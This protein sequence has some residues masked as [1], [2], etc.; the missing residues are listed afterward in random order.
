[1]T[2]NAA[3]SAKDDPRTLRTVVA[4]SAAG[5]AF[6]WYDFFIFGSLTAV[7]ARHFYADVSEATGY[8]L[9]L[10]TFG[11]G[12]VVRP[13]GA[14]VFGWFGDRTGRKKTFL[15]TITLMGVATVAIGLL[16]DY[17]Q[18]GLAAP[19]LLI[20]MRILQGFALGGEYGGA[21]IYVAEHA[22]ARKRG[23]LT[24]WIQTTAAL[25][26]IGALSVILITRAIVG[27]EAFDEWGWRIPFL[28]SALLL[29]VSLW[30][31]MKLD[32]SPAYERMK[33]EAGEK[34][35]PYV[36]S[37]LRWKNGRFVLIALFGIMI[38]Q[39]AVWYCGYFYAR[40]FM[41]RVLKVEVNTVDQLML[42][43]TALSAFLYVFFAWLSD[44]VGRKPVML[45]G[46]ILA[47]VAYFPGFQALT[48]AANPAL[49]E[50]QATAPVTVV[51]DPA[52]CAVQFD[53][54]GKTAFAS[55]C[56]IAKNVLSNAGISYANEAAAPGT[57]AVVRVGAATVPSVE[58]EGMDPAALKAAR[59]DVEGR[60][61]GALVA[62]GYPE[63]ADPART[64]LPAVFGILMIFI[65]AATAL[66]GPQAA[67]L[68][69]LFPTRVRYTAMSLP[70]H[71]GTGWV[72]GLL[73]AA[74]F[75]L[76]AW[77]GNIYFGLWYSVA[78]TG[79]AVLVALIWLPETKGRDLD[80]IGR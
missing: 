37:F 68:V 6:E 12:F 14:L 9:A 53:P 56:D 65:V 36:E 10:L 34:R 69:E 4:A 13:L 61:K 2:D 1:M 77:S 16:P 58:G 24:G 7:I 60:I 30:I 63:R 23:L 32:E 74:S 27:A 73:P 18:I 44:R 43:V 5:T 50:A 66:Y 49:A 39:G 75:A 55:S 38:A 57:L 29:A 79:L 15:V 62:A 72:G 59:T 47:L 25:G 67:A 45:F 11:V 71:V 76:V 19:V 42:A 51:A 21:A 54:V 46:M 26:L 78:F 80:T 3:T 28:L 31:R 64:N 40:F 17:D 22:P 48:R 35:A 33:A 20:L 52:T 41:E 8:I 70:Y